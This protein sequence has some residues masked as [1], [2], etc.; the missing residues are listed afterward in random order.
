[1][2]EQGDRPQA[3]YNWNCSEWKKYGGEDAYGNRDM[4]IK[5]FRD[6]TFATEPWNIPSSSA[7]LLAYGIVTNLQMNNKSYYCLDL[8]PMTLW[9]KENG[10]KTE[11]KVKYHVKVFDRHPV[12]K[13]KPEIKQRKFVGKD[14]EATAKH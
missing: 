3:S 14:F 8:V 1:M 13:N 6:V 5:H 12:G 11:Y 10:S 2:D 7:N 9:K 4:Y